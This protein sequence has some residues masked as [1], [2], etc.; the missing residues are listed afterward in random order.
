[1]DKR[2]AVSR[3]VKAT[4]FTGLVLVTLA[5]S[6]H[7]DGP[8]Q[9]AEAFAWNGQLAAPGTLNIRNTNGAITV[10]PSADNTVRVTAEARWH[11]G[12]WRRDVSFVAVPAGSDVTVCAIW[13]RGTC[14]AA[15]YA[16]GRKRRG[17]NFS[18]NKSN[19]TVAFKVQVPAGVKVDGYT[20][21]GPITVRAAAP[22]KARTLNGNV[23]VGTAVGPVDAETLNGDVDIRMTTIGSDL[24]PVRAVTKNGTATAYVPDILDGRIKASTLTGELGTDFGG[25][26]AGTRGPGRQFVTTFGQGA[27]EYVV[28]T[29]NGSAWLRLINADGSVG[30]AGTKAAVVVSPTGTGSVRSIQAK[31]IP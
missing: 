16:S 24:G 11:K 20:M 30:T 14:S 23:V 25:P 6:C 22:V 17:W 10:E 31:R 5:A 13:N 18:F 12:D 26:A 7:P 2:R 21:N 8:E 9:V 1:M 27:R 3:F 29:L 28:E 15:G 4:L 19:A